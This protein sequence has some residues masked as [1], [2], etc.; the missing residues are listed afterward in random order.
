[1]A[2][3]PEVTD[4]L[5]DTSRLEARLGVAGQK[6]DRTVGGDSV[7]D[8]RAREAMNL[9]ESHLEPMGGDAFGSGFALVS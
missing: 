1:M 5:S 8:F 6:L 2:H 3:G 7:T 4:A 9:L